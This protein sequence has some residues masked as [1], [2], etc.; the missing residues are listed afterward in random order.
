MD[1]DVEDAAQSSRSASRK[2]FTVPVDDEH[3][4]DLD[5]YISNYSGMQLHTEEMLFI[6]TVHTGRT[7]VDRLVHIVATC[8][9]IASQAFH[10]A[11]QYIHQLRDPGLYQTALS[12]YEQCSET[13][14]AHDALDPNWIEETMS[15]NQ[16]D[17][18]KLEVELK[19]YTNNMIK[20]SIRVT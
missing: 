14:D 9:S 8:P 17:R 16:R 4:F 3:P 20:E 5:S 1:I 11:V 13:P 2:P 12:V 7:A 10:L 18:V 15:N 19:A 6:L